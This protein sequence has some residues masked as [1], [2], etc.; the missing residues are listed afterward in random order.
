MTG[1]ELRDR[2][3]ATIRVVDGASMILW[4]MLRL[5]EHDEMDGLRMFG[6]LDD[7]ACLASGTRLRLAETEPG[8]D[9]ETEAVRLAYRMA[10][11]RLEVAAG[12]AA[13]SLASGDGWAPTPVTDAISGVKAIRAIA[14][15]LGTGKAA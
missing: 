10:M 11:G 3:E 13:Y 15:A 14:A 2:I 1:D 9:Q 6:A 5:Q 7:L 8:E 12:S 4:G